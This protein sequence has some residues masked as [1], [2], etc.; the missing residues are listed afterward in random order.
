MEL[1]LWMR[2]SSCLRGVSGGRREE[3]IATID[4]KPPKTIVQIVSVSMVV[5]MN[6][7]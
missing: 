7:D 5:M 6:R 1:L 3:S 4:T 2:L